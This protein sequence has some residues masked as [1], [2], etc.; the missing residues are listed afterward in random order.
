MSLQKLSILR[1][2]RR[3]E[4]RIP[5]IFDHLQHL[6]S[7]YSDCL[8]F[9][10]GYGQ[11]VGI[12][13]SAIGALGFSVQSRKRLLQNEVAFLILKPTM[14]DYMSLPIGAVVIGWIHA[15]QS[16][17]VVNIATKKRLTLIAL[18]SCFDT[19]GRHILHKNNYIAGY[20]GVQHALAIHSLSPC[21]KPKVCIIGYGDVGR[22]ALSALRQLDCDV[23][24]YTRYPVNMDIEPVKYKQV[25]RHQG[26]LWY[27]KAPIA[28][29]LGKYDII[30]NAIK[31]DMLS[32]VQFICTKQRHFLK[33]GSLIVDL[34]CDP[35][36][37]FYFAQ[38]TKHACP[39]VSV[40][41]VNYYSISN[42]P[43]LVFDK[44]SQVISEALTK[45]I[46]DFFRL[47]SG[48]RSLFDDAIEIANGVIINQTIIQFQQRVEHDLGMD[49]IG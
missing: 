24:V 19:A 23:T 15:V 2:Q 48:E 28:Q 10:K 37:G 42:V 6:A 44:S 40:A 36:L 27:D 30:I 20:Q 34:S 41:G 49:A 29:E 46:G 17:E 26:M 47:L 21:L 13:N 5:F 11:F 12:S 18:E 4:Q 33:R 31:Q 9:E 8:L 1:S 3:D 14:D 43:S 7:E 45:H 16:P 25:V 22:G 32:P 38:E 39:L 35:N